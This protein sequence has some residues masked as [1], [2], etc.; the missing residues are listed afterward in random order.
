MVIEIGK[1]YNCGNSCVWSD[2]FEENGDYFVVT[3]YHE[4]NPEIYQV[5]FP[6]GKVECFWKTSMVAENVKEYKTNSEGKSVVTTRV[7]KEINDGVYGKL[8]VDTN[9]VPFGSHKRVRLSLL[10]VGS[11][12]VVSEAVVF[13]KQELE[14]LIETLTQIK[15]AM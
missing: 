9:V 1:K 6:N 5:A 10:E 15:D 14:E 2:L 12:A 8:F 3:G 13:E 7:V 11:F 4:N